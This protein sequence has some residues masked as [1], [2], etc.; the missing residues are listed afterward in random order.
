L[1]LTIKR[2][3][4]L[5]AMAVDYGK[6]SA[7]TF[8]DLVAFA[9]DEDASIARRVLRVRVAPPQEGAA[10]AEQRRV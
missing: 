5:R 7:D 8:A 6:S 4:A 1:T 3:E 2:E 10:R 9:L